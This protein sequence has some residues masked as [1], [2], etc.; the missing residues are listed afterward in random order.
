MRCSVDA[1]RELRYHQILVSREFGGGGQIGIQLGVFL[2][3]QGRDCRIWVPGSGPAQSEVVRNRLPVSAYDMN[4]AFS[5]FALRAMCANWRLGRALKRCGPGLVHVHS[6]GHYGALRWGLK[7]SRVTRVV[8][9]HSEEPPE[10]LG[11]ALRS[12]PEVIV[13]CAGFLVA[14]VGKCLPAGAR[15]PQIVSVPNAVDTARFV[16]GSKIAAK[17]DIGADPEEPLGLMLA[18]LTPNKGQET[19]IRV[20]AELKS[21]GIDVQFWLAGV[22]RGGT[23]AYT[24]KLR[25]LIEELG[26]HDRVRLVGQRSDAPGLL[27]A[28]DFFLLPSTTEGLPLTVLE[29]H[30][31]KT[32]VLASPVGGIP[33]VVEDNVTGFL[34]AADDVGGYVDRITRLLTQEGLGRRLTEAAYEQVRREHNWDTYCRRIMAVYDDEAIRGRLGT[35]GE[36]TSRG[37][38]SLEAAK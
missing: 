28:A 33:E 27:R 20:A 3:Q 24:S 21:R 12:P 6:P 4:S 32:P 15:Q 35:I 34:I 13:T 10:L 8:H 14:H 29:A 25:A 7:K 11:W 30:A 2:N 17:A 16:P 36:R 9:V 23:T 26:V 1:K 37:C 18:N 38:Q 5:K 31:S 19:S 22:E